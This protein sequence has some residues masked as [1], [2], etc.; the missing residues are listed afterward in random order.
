MATI[1]LMIGIIAIIAVGAIILTT[2]NIS[3]NLVVA[4]NPI[5][6]SKKYGASDF[7]IRINGKNPSLTEFPPRYRELKFH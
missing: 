6:D 5:S 1:S 7:I 4:N 2:N 3:A